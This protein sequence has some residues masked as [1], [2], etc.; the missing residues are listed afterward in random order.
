VFQGG[1]FLRIIKKKERGYRFFSEK[2]D[3]SGSYAGKQGI[4]IGVLLLYILVKTKDFQFAELTAEAERGIGE[5]R[6]ILHVP[7]RDEFHIFSNIEVLSETFQQQ[8]LVIWELKGIYQNVDV[9]ITG[10]TYGT[11][12]SV[13]TPLDS[14]INMIP[15][16][17]AAESA[18]YDY[19]DYD[20]KMIARLKAKYHLNQKIA[21]QTIVGLQKHP[22]VWEEFL[23]GLQTTPFLFPKEG[24][25]SVKGYTAEMLFKNCPLSELGAY[26]Y[27]IYLRNDPVSA[28]SDL[29]RG[30]PRR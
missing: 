1:G 29:K 8:K 19:Y 24:A 6:N 10:R 20:D 2:Y 13:R 22:D 26:N 11:V 25:V 27:L 5:E 15:L 16:M 21:I 30:L 7:K 28:M 12:L 18:T 9:A 3:L 23:N 4:A 17:S 14:K